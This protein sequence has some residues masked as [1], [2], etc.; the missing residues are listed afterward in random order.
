MVESTGVCRMTWRQLGLN[1]RAQLVMMKTRTGDGERTA[2][3]VPAL[4][5][6]R[7]RVSPWPRAEHVD[8]GPDAFVPTEQYCCDLGAGQCRSDYLGGLLKLKCNSIEVC[9]L[10]LIII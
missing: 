4:G 8:L 3:V 7:P 1:V 2:S 9:S 5:A 10:L 6:P